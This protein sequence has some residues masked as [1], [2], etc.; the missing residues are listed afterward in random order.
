[1]CLFLWLPLERSILMGS[2]LSCCGIGTTEDASHRQET[3]RTPLLQDP[4][5]ILP[6]ARPEPNPEDEQR[7]QEAL[8]KIVKKTSE[9]L[10]DIQ[11]TFHTRADTNMDVTQRVAQFDYLYERLLNTTCS[12]EDSGVSDRY[13]PLSKDDTPLKVRKLKPVGDII[14]KL[15]WD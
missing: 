12:N 10:I 15:S 5:A 13:V 8:A 7:E 4:S 2:C 3:E 9:S 1:M 11:A 14:V 6:Q